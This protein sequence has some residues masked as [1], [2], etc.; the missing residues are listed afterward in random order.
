MATNTTQISMEF[1]H[2]DRTLLRLR[3]QCHRLARL[4]LVEE[5]QCVDPGVNGP[6]NNSVEWQVKRGERLLTSDA[7][8]NVS[9]NDSGS[10]VVGFLMSS[11]YIFAYY[12]P[13]RIS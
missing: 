4:E 13:V 11:L 6:P 12:L 1:R 5:G 3:G 9:A 8:A 10:L 7:L 2:R